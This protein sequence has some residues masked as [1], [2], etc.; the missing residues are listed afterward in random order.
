MCAAERVFDAD[1][2]LVLTVLAA[3]SNADQR[4][5]S[6]ALSAAAIA[7]VVANG[8][9]VALDGRH[10]DR[11]ARRRST[12]LRPLVRLATETD[13]GIIAA[14]HPA[15]IGLQSA[16]ADYRDNLPAVR[17]PDCASSLIHMHANRLLGD[18]DTERIA[19]ALAADILA[20]EAL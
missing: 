16:L 11:A 13:S 10:I 18:L 9:R 7:R 5:V 1:S 14:T 4:L 12:D 20:R 2:R 3:T 8:D 17:R 19:R 15:W 6:A